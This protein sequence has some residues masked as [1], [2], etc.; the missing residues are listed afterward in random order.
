[1]L[2]S[3][4]RLARPHSEDTASAPS[5]SILRGL[6]PGLPPPSGSSEDTAVGCVCR[7]CGVVAH[8]HHGKQQHYRRDTA[9][10]RAP[11]L[12]IV[13]R[14]RACDVVVEGLPGLEAE[15]EVVGQNRDGPPLRAQPGP[16]S[17]LVGNF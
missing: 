1:M 3:A 5:R 12:D 16:H 15:A 4:C 11:L 2:D 9:S 7:K 13:A 8:M 6:A 10:A 14:A 17:A